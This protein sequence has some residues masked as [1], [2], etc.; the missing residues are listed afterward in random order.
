[1]STVSAL[2]AGSSSLAF[3]SGGGE[4]GAR[5]RS[6]DWPSHPLGPPELWPQS[7]KTIVRVMLDSRYAMWMAWGPQLTFFCN[8]A[9][10]PTVGLKRDWVLG[11]RSVEMHGG[12]ITAVLAE[13]PS[14]S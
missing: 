8:D 6:L 11:A 10:L 2:P 13:L 1:M 3:L 9:Y 5:L 4:T 14:P 7:L 12:R